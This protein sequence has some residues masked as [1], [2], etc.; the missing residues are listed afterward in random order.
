MLNFWVR[1]YLTVTT[2]VLDI[3]IWFIFVMILTEILCREKVI[4]PSR[5][6]YISFVGKKK[7]KS[8][9][10]ISWNNKASDKDSNGGNLGTY[11]SASVTIESDYFCATEI[12]F[13]VNYKTNSCFIS[14][15]QY[16]IRFLTQL[17]S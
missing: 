17:M 6:P 4:V 8:N 13:E 16:R 7:Q 15:K 2:W 3:G 11:R 12:T 1:G 14:E 10:I 5:K 9:T